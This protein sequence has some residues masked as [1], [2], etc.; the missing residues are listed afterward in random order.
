MHP[1]KSALS[2]NTTASTYAARL[3]DM[4]RR[5][6]QGEALQPEKLAAEYEV[7]LRTV[8]RDLNEKLDFLELEVHNG[9]YRVAAS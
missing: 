8:Q 3:V 2:R 6:N 4:L 7:T 5:L 1:K 9:S